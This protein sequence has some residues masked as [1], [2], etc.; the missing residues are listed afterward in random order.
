M[1]E[2]NSQSTGE[3]YFHVG[4]IY[5]GEIYEKQPYGQGTLRMGNVS[6]FEGFFENKSMQ[7]GTFS[8]FTGIE[9]EG[10]FNKD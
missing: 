10:L 6:T 4:E 8:F 5:S 2:D 3:I 9:F 1:D 7:E